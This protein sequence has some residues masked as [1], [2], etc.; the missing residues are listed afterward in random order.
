MTTSIAPRTGGEIGRIAPPMERPMQSLPATW[1]GVVGGGRFT[2]F[3]RTGS[4]S[5]RLR[6]RE[7]RHAA[8]TAAARYASAP[9]SVNSF[10]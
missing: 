10:G 6:D 7:R 9:R 8:P 5:W 1:S 2:S 4:S 3:R